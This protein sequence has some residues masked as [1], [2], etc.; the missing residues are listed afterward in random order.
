MAH[1]NL[2]LLAYWLVTTIQNQLK[3]KGYNAQWREIVRTMNIQKCVTTTM[4][5]I[6]N[7][8]ISIRQCTEPNQNPSF[9]NSFKYFAA[10]IIDTPKSLLMRKV[11]ILYILNLKR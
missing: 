7:E 8:M 3:Q 6:D 9:A 11:N 5:N 4:E 2:G 10:V 1:L